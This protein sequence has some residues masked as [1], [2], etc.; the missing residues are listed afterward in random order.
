MLRA[1]TRRTT[2]SSSVDLT[3]THGLG[4][5]PDYWG[6]EPVSDVSQGLA[7]VVPGTVLTNIINVTVPISIA[8]LDI[9]TINYQG[10]LY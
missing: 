2:A 6:I 3:V 7:Y 4:A 5:V 1:R 10:R 8:T 9:F